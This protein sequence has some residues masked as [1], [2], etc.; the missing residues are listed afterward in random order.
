MTE[1]KECAK[2]IHCRTCQLI[3]ELKTNDKWLIILCGF[4]RIYVDSNLAEKCF[5]YK[6]KD[7]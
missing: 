7:D 6:K 4:L 5:H 2:C 3:R 1:I